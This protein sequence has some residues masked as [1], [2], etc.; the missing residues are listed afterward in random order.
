M[1]VHGVADYTSHEQLFVKS[2]Q[3][4]LYSPT[5]YLFVFSPSPLTLVTAR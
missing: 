2:R 1:R 5:T 3:V 4:Q